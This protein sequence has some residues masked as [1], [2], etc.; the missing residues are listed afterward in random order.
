MQQE[1]QLCKRLRLLF[2]HGCFCVQGR[3]FSCGVT[4][5]APC[6]PTPPWRAPTPPPEWTPG[7][8]SSAREAP[9]PSRCPCRHGQ[10]VSMHA[11]LGRHNAC[12]AGS[13]MAGCQHAQACQDQ[14][15]EGRAMQQAAGRG[16]TGHHDVAGVSMCAVWRAG[17]RLCRGVW[18]SGGARVDRVE[19]S[20]QGAGG[21]G[22]E[23]GTS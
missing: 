21:G 3:T 8:A 17:C 6:A 7:R 15:R 11:R 16:A 10:G 20:A 2:V 9:A 13:F 4:C 1:S 23:S 19:T 14:Q 18:Q 5:S 22:G 12:M